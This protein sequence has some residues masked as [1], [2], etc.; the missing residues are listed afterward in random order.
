MAKEY[1]EIGENSIIGGKHNE[2]HQSKFNSKN[3][4]KI[5]YFADGK[6]A[7]EAFKLLI[8]DDSIAIQFICLR[9][10]TQDK[11]LEHLAKQHKIDCFIHRDVNSF[12]FIEKLNPINV[13][14]LYL[15][16]LTRFLNQK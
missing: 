8:K 15:C 7:H 12:E 1:I 2:E 9:H 6:W 14:Y 5:G 11:I 13:I 16:H 10:D 4:L 3:P